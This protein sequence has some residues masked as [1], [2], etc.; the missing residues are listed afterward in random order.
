MR[1][2]RNEVPEAV[3]RCA[4]PHSCSSVVRGRP[5]ALSKPQFPQLLKEVV[6]SSMS[7]SSAHRLSITVLCGCSLV[8]LLRGEIS[9]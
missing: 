4:H 5:A 9:R 7:S 2:L 1:T 8:D 6:R 3:L